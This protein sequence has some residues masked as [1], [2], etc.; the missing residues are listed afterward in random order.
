MISFAR[1]SSTSSGS[2]LASTGSGEVPSDGMKV[3]LTFVGSMVK[4]SPVE[5]DG[6]NGMDPVA[7]RMR[8]QLWTGSVMN[9][10]NKLI[11]AHFAS[12]P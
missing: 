10:H 11:Q 8:P 6:N 9:S 4:G 3:T 2:P 7:A 12:S 5:D 1:T